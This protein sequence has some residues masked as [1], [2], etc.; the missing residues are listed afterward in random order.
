VLAETLFL[1]SQAHFRYPRLLLKII[2][3]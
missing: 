3:S 2:I 1:A